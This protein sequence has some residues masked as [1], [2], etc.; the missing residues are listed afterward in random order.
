MSRTVDQR[1]V[2]MKFDNKQ[3]ETAVNQS[4]T[5]I[6]NLEQDINMLDGIKALNN[7]DK[8]ISKV[9]FSHMARSIDNIKGAFSTLGTIGR[10]ILNKM[11]T[12]AMNNLQNTASKIETTIKNLGKQIYERGY[13][14]ASNLE[15]SAFKIEG[16]LKRSEM[17]AL[18]SAETQKK[19]SD[20]INESVTDTA[21][22]LD[23]AS[24]VASTLASTFGTDEQALSKIHKALNAVSGVAGTTGAAYEQV[25]DIFTDAAGKG[26]AMGDEF[27]RMSLLGISAQEEVARY[28]NKNIK[29]QGKL[30]KIL[31]KNQKHV[32]TG[33]EI[34]TLASKRKIDADIF[35]GAFE[36]F[37][38]TAK[39]ANDTMEGITDNIGAAMGRLGA[40]FIQPIIANRGPLVQFLQ[41]V[42]DGISSVAKLLDKLQIPKMVTDF[43]NDV[44]IDGTKHLKKFID[45]FKKGT[46]PLNDFFKKAK[47]V[48]DK[49]TIIFSLTEHN[50]GLYEKFGGDKKKLENFFMPEELATR[51][52]NASDKLG[53][54]Y[55]SWDEYY[56]LFKKNK[57]LTKDQKWLG[58][59]ESYLKQMND[60]TPKTKKQWEELYKTYSRFQEV[61]KPDS[62]FDIGKDGKIIVPQEFKTYWET[63]NNVAKT[64][65]G[66][67]FA[68]QQKAAG[69]S[70]YDAADAAAKLHA[71]EATVFG[72][73][74]LGDIW[75][76]IVNI[77]STIA[78]I[79][80]TIGDAIEVADGPLKDF[81]NALSGDSSDEDLTKARRLLNSITES[82]KNATE[83]FKEFVNSDEGK[84]TIKAIASYV[85]TF[86]KIIGGVFTVVGKIVSV[87]TPLI[88][89][90]F[91]IVGKILG[92]FVQESEGL[93]V[94]DTIVNGLCSAIE[95]LGNVIDTV[96]DVVSSA[97]DWLKKNGFFDFLSGI[98]TKIGEFG[99]YIFNNWPT[100]WDTITGKLKEFKDW[101]SEKVQ[102]IIEKIKPHFDDLCTKI[103]DLTDGFVNLKDPIDGIKKIFGLTEDEA[104]GVTTAVDK[105]D[106]ALS[107]VKDTAKNVKDNITMGFSGSYL[108]RAV[109]GLDLSGDFSQYMEKTGKDNE[110]LKNA[111]KNIDETKGTISDIA[112]GVNDINNLKSKN[113][114]K[115]K[116]KGILAT[117]FEW[118]K[119]FM[120][121][122]KSA[123][124]TGLDPKEIGEA[125]KKIATICKTVVVVWVGWKVIGAVREFMNGLSNF[126]MAINGGY[127]AKTMRREAI[128]KIFKAIAL[129]VGVFVVGVIAIAVVIKKL[130][131]LPISTL[132][133]G[134]VAFAII[135]GVIIYIIRTVSDFA[136]QMR[137]SAKSKKKN[138]MKFGFINVPMIRR[139][140]EAEGVK[141]S[142]FLPLIGIAACI[143]VFAAGVAAIGATIKML[144]K[145]D[146]GQLTQGIIAFAAI[147]G[148]MI[149][150]VALVFTFLRMMLDP[151]DISPI[152]DFR[153]S[154]DPVAAFNPHTGERITSNQT[155]PKNLATGIALTLFGVSAVLM[156]FSN[157]VVKIATA[158]KL[159]SMLPGDSI[160]RTIPI[161]IGIAIALI[162]LIALVFFF[163]NKMLKN[164]NQ[165]ESDVGISKALA[166]ILGAVAA[167]LFAFA[168]AVKKIAKAIANLAVLS[169]IGVD[170]DKAATIVG[171]IGA[172]LI[173]LV[174]V[175]MV[176][177]WLIFKQ[178]KANLNWKK[179][180]VVFG[181]VAAIII[182]FGITM[183]IIAGG[184]A[185]VAKAFE[186]LSK[187]QVE[188]VT[189]MMSLVMLFI[190]AIMV[191]LIGG[192]LLYARNASGSMSKL[193]VFFAGM[194]TV[195]GVVAG[196][197]VALGYAASLMKDLDAG[198][199]KWL[200]ISLGI[201]GGIIVALMV[202]AYVTEKLGGIK[203]GIKA[204][205]TIIIA[206]GA[207]FALI[208][209]AAYLIGK[210]A[211][212]FVSAIERFMDA[213]NRFATMKDKKIKKGA[214]KVGSAVR[215]FLNGLID[216]IIKFGDD[217]DGKKEA[218]KGAITKILNIIQESITTFWVT[219][220]ANILDRLGQLIDKLGPW[221]ST[222]GPKLTKI[223]QQLENIF[224]FGLIQPFFYDLGQFILQQ[225]SAAIDWIN[226]HK[227]DLIQDFIDFGCD[228]LVKL[229]EGITNNTDKI[230]SALQIAIHSLINL[231]CAF[232]GIDPPFDDVTE[233]IEQFEENKQ[234]EKL[235]QSIDD[236]MAKGIDKGAKGVVD[237]AK[238]LIGKIGDAIWEEIITNEEFQRITN[239]ISEVCYYWLHPWESPEF[240][241]ASGETQKIIT[242]RTQKYVDELIAKGMD[243]DEAIKKGAEY[244][245]ALTQ[246]FLKA[247]DHGL[248]SHSPSKE[249]EKRGKWIDQGLENGIVKNSKIV[250]SAA[251]K[252]ADHINSA[253]DA[254]LFNPNDKT[255]QKAMTASKIFENLGSN[256]KKS[257]PKL[258][259]V[260][261]DSGL[262]DTDK[263][264]IKPG[265]DL[266]NITK[267]S[268]QLQKIFD[269]VGLSNVNAG[270][271]IGLFDNL[272]KGNFNKIDVSSLANGFDSAN[273]KNG[274][275]SSSD[276]L[277]SL[278]S[279][280]FTQNNY[281]PKSL[282]QIDIYRQTE[283]LL[284]KQSTLNSLAS[285]VGLTGTNF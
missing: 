52:K 180:L 265:M 234:P 226:K 17:D 153:G 201:I 107:N 249:M 126:S 247:T 55:K 114:T 69:Q 41:V 196:M 183:R 146:I 58:A 209:A 250:I 219:L 157:A 208:G 185:T 207:L 248:D 137:G 253:Y 66:E 106:T 100:I 192:V 110:N 36:G 119:D 262:F 28:V 89:K 4:R 127:D 182:V 220:E 178:G 177:A 122:A 118:L 86:F 73:D 155:K 190:A 281:S 161:F 37:I 83:Q 26:K 81:F 186:G 5:S 8:T 167:I 128:A 204:V 283:N 242:E 150:L 221:L 113:Q 108:G 138:T 264:I 213:L 267:D 236:K 129:L 173:A 72:H 101:I 245:K 78:D 145:M 212:L 133:K 238:Q 160:N 10:S 273:D 278:G 241:I 211:D 216:A 199:L 87:V 261:E 16:L 68:E 23:Q 274:S 202:F 156:S 162:G 77:G 217:V 279:I 165:Y 80:I 50:T 252:Q 269:G 141:E 42:K 20:M 243:K 2:E 7:L 131:E 159:I 193:I 47:D 140:L 75:D 123:L 34:L 90:A 56:K 44:I 95:W 272:K 164:G 225:A 203:T 270:E 46:T 109:T 168:V 229:G 67:K 176:F 232:L 103:K 215:E 74:W 40:L 30:N 65:A 98:I 197:I 57:S 214:K 54:S 24:L 227:G 130:G 205:A 15:N 277:A 27:S 96:L 172:G 206:L 43:F 104:D 84:A 139:N 166:P 31:K 59:T 171:I 257:L 117:V 163:L 9:D 152:A 255:K 151:K 63:I 53:K 149:V 116:K 218:L 79:F 154:G 188:H 115:N 254:A 233:K 271:A 260:I 25:A 230:V 179:V 148:V 21:F 134:I 125:F 32:I 187:S 13:R 259:K 231:F 280:N 12:D 169:T 94:V 158:M 88:S 143:A 14:R 170:M 195:L 33:D 70:M 181:S 120:G 124:L 93:D 194:A 184:I 61:K 237:A 112:N 263:F 60:T 39:E 29:L 102:P 62:L 276:P 235:G 76:G 82:F 144:G 284:G 256:F 282:S 85:K 210:G 92:S 246:G 18:Q 99:S 135:S 142:A 38:D 105:V 251:Y 91:G 48:I 97:V 228:M 147:S 22:G 198:T 19:L 64:K 244:G 275:K 136:I 45:E 121:K 239:Y 6:K 258:T 189:I 191:I 11:T 240:G 223:L 49:L 132:I 200:V 111:K 222:Y 174:A 35:V 51:A 266:S 175:V 3:F 268:K 1:V 285:S 224:W 71:T